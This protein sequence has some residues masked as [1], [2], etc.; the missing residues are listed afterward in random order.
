MLSDQNVRYEGMVDADSKLNYNASKRFR[1]VLGNAGSVH[2]T[3]NGQSIDEE[4]VGKIGEVRNIV[5]EPDTIRA[6]TII[7]PKKDE[8]N[9]S[10]T[11]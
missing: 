5:I 10:E 7:I 6:Y 2:L 8:N 1:V 9:P 3:F 11:N 4:T